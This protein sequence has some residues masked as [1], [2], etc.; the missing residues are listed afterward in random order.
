MWR[1]FGILEKRELNKKEF[2]VLMKYYFYM[3]QMLSI[4]NKCYSGLAA[5]Q[6]P[7]VSAKNFMV[8]KTINIVD[9]HMWLLQTKTLWKYKNCF[10]LAL[11]WRDSCLFKDIKEMRT[12]ADLFPRPCIWSS[13]LFSWF[14]M[15]KK[16]RALTFRKYHTYWPPP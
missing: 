8:P 2:C 13:R 6:Q 4:P 12:M 15:V 16:T 11:K 1:Y 10:W 3:K 7:F 14:S 9:V 5:S